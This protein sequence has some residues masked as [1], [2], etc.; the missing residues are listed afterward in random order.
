M[1][2]EGWAGDLLRFIPIPEDYITNNAFGGP[3]M[4]TLYVSTG[5]AAF[6]TVVVTILFG[7]FSSLDAQRLS[8]GVMSGVQGIPAVRSVDLSSYSVSGNFSKR[9][10]F[11]PTLEWRLPFDLS[12]EAD[13]LHRQIF[14]HVE[15]IERSATQFKSCA[16]QDGAIGHSVSSASCRVKTLWTCF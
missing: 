10:V 6:F 4:K 16:T 15:F 8:V 11:G 3:D 12:L 5:K 1:W 7:S 13:V 14:G 9:L 2:F